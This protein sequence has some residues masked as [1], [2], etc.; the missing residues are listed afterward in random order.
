MKQFISIHDVQ[1]VP[2]LVQDGIHQKKSALHP[3]TDHRMAM[4][5][6]F[7]NSS[8]RTRLS[9]EKACHL[10][11][12][13][14]FVLNAGQSWPLEFG[15]GVIMDGDKS[16]HIKEA[17]GVISQYADLIG[18]RAF[19]Q[20]MDR[21]TD[22]SEPIIGGFEKYASSPIVNLESATRHP[23]Q[24]LADM[25]TIEEYKKRKRPKVVLTWAPHPKALPQSVA[26]SFAAW[27]L[28]MDYEVVITHPEG[29]E[30]DP[31]ITFGASIE[32]D[33]SRAYE[34]ADF[35]YAKNWSSYQS[36][37]QI[38]SQDS[39]WLVDVEK[40]SKANEAYFMHC[41][42]VRRN[43]VVE[44]KIIESQQ[45]LVMQQATNRTFSMLIVLEQILRH[46]NT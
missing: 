6:I 3:G 4:A 37:G 34:N 33:P 39:R 29:Y 46:M 7:F 40:F 19:P 10:L 28:A 14:S 32:Y 35:I 42:P 43:V 38:L 44:D 22:Y 20:L 45:S 5:L 41:L 16:E 15:E 23:L 27:S 2:E 12:L 36:Y 18:V 8:L 25:I 13:T 9:S 17:S 24:G 31:T 1:D 26:N 21:D 30:L 11:G